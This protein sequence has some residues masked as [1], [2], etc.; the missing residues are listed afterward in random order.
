LIESR[1]VARDGS[2]ACSHVC[3]GA[4]VGLALFFALL[5]LGNRL[6]PG[7]RHWAFAL[8]ALGAYGTAAKSAQVQQARLAA[9]AAAWAARDG[10]SAASAASNSAK[11]S[12]WSQ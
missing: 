10:L 7:H 12:G 3:A 8:A 5:A 4:I 1:P 9:A 11:A 2:W 6:F